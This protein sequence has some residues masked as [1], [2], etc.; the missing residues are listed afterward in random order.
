MTVRQHFAAAAALAAITLNLVFWCVPLVVLVLV[1]GIAPRARAWTQSAGEAIYR[2]AVAVDDW[3]LRRVSGAAWHCPDPAPARNRPCIVIAN[4]RSW[5]DVFL[6]QS[7]VARRGP[8]VKFL[9]KRE[10]VW[11]PIL[12]LI[13][14]AFDFPVV[15][16]RGSRRL[17]ESE[18]R[19]ADRHRVRE[20]CETL[21]TRPAAML[22]FVEGTRFTPEKHA[23]ASSP[24]R[25]LLPPKSGGF[26][27]I[28]ENLR[29]VEARVLDLTLCY[30]RTSAFWAFLGG[31]AGEI[32]VRAESFALRNVLAAG[33]RDWLEERWRAK[34]E[35]LARYR[36]HPAPDTRRT[37][38]PRS[39]KPREIM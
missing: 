14:L 9:C 36:G 23:R 18:R 21:R 28:V 31:A 38:P 27:A 39:R 11:I 26:E 17:P 32:E 4:H 2:F 1:R 33:P 16:R 15:R 5:A 13:F 3:W 24:Y 29:G 8:I 25:C 37:P 6:I 12:G 35:A 7:A 34:D 20:A 30:P 19:A 22:T 10:L